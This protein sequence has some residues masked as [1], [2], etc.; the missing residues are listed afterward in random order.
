MPSSYKFTIDTCTVPV[1]PQDAVR[2]YIYNYAQMVTSVQIMPIISSSS[3]LLLNR[4]TNVDFTQSLHF[5][6]F[7]VDNIFLGML[8]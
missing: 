8:L 1:K 7:A 2:M 3:S 4:A 6:M 5:T